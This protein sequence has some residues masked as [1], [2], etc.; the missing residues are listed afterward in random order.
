MTIP[1]QIREDMISIQ[2]LFVESITEGRRLKPSEAEEY[3]A[4]FDAAV[5]AITAEKVRPT[6]RTIHE[7]DF[8]KKR[9]NDQL[10]A[11]TYWSIAGYEGQRYYFYTPDGEGGFWYDSLREMLSEHNND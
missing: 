2:T 10:P 1:N 6:V 7:S 3:R 9:D 5:T 8:E 4:M 11:D